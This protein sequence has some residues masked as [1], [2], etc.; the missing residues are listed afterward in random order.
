MSLLL[1]FGIGKKIVTERFSSSLPPAW[2]YTRND[3]VT[4]YRDSSG[5]MR[6]AGV[7]APPIDHTSAGVALGLRIQPGTTN[8]LTSANATITTTGTYIVASGGTFS[9]PSDTAALTAAGLQSVGNGHV[10]KIAN[11]TGSDIAVYWAVTTGNTNA[12]SISMYA[13]TE[14]DV[15]GINPYIFLTDFGGNNNGQKT[16]YGTAYQ[17]VT[18]EGITPTN[19]N[20]RLALIVPTGQT[21]YFL[22]AQMEALSYATDPVITTD[23]AAGTRAAPL[24]KRSALW[25]SKN[26]GFAIKY[27]DD[28]PRS[29]ASVLDCLFH[30]GEANN[31]YD[32]FKGTGGDVLYRAFNG[33][34]DTINYDFD[35]DALAAGPQSVGMGWKE[36]LV[37]CAINGVQVNTNDSVTLPASFTFGASIGMFESSL[38]PANIWLETATLFRRFPSKAQIE[39]ATRTTLE[40]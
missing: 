34:S 7:N 12:H 28:A 15:S 16:F 24:L 27:R 40:V 22:L 17:R 14:S 4:T 39:A 3:A 35:G 19:S 30:V 9:T 20:Q 21:V 6:V 37:R 10:Y 1:P 11:A 33:G 2:A 8:K 38:F 26:G 36:G 23:G 18:S 5:V 13:R 25:F 31:R 29:P 32:I